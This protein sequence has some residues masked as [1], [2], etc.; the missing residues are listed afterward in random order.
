MAVKRTCGGAEAYAEH[1]TETCTY[2]EMKREEEMAI[3]RG[4]RAKVSFC[5][6]LQLF[7]FRLAVPELVRHGAYGYDS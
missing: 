1:Q 6:Q 4:I 3:K 2:G 7:L 5:F